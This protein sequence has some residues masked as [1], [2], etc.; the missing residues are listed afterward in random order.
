MSQKTNAEK[1]I[2]TLAKDRD[3]MDFQRLNKHDP[4]R[5]LVSGVI[6]ARTKDEVTYPATIRLFEKWKS[7]SE[8]SEADPEDVA[9]IIYPAG[10]YKTKGET[11][12]NLASEICSR[13][14]GKTPDNMKDLTSLKGIGRKIAN[15]VLTLG[16]GIPGITVD[17]HV[18]RISNRV[19]W[20]NTKTPD[21]TE[22][23]LME[24]LPKDLWIISNE[25]LVRLGQEV[26]K[27]IRPNCDICKIVEFCDYQSK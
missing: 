10:F 24:L 27:P 13:F 2:L 16:Y 22:K 26:C 3:G 14:N 8:L 5:I 23:A 9:K 25:L 12:V 19:G 15:L 7:T 11:L 4:F 20:V 17:S 18:H 21:Q 6:S 1:A